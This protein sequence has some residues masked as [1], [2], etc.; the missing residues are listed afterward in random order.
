MKTLTALLLLATVAMA[1][2]EDVRITEVMF[3][4]SDVQLDGNP[5]NSLEWVEIQNTGS[6]SVTVGYNWELVVTGSG[7]ITMNGSTDLAPGEFAVIP[8]FAYW[9]EQHY[10]TGF[11]LIPTFGTP[12][13]AND[14]QTL[15]LKYNG[16]I[17]ETLH[18]YGDWGSDY[19]DN[20]TTPDCDG[21]GA[22]LERANATGDPNDPWNWESSMDEAS[23]IPDEDWPGHDESWG[24]PCTPN[25]V[26]GQALQTATWGAIKAALAN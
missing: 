16:N 6:T 21:D 4:P 19:G 3:H 7:T 17:V 25:T 12:T 1:Y 5:E 22:S 15:I 23:G 10:G 26:E 2:W 8:V 14:S 9:F 11:T 18:Y 20:N 13:F 24:T